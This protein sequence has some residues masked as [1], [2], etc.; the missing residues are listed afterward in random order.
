LN[1]KLACNV[2]R[3]TQTFSTDCPIP[4]FGSRP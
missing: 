1:E 4:F 3:G 2:P